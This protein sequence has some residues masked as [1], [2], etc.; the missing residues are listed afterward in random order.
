MHGWRRPQEH[1][2][3]RGRTPS[4]SALTHLRHTHAQVQTHAPQE[5]VH[6]VGPVPVIGTVVRVGRQPIHV[7]VAE[8]LVRRWLHLVQAVH[9]AVRLVPHVHCA[10]HL[11]A[12][13][14]KVP[15]A[16]GGG[17]TPFLGTGH[18]STGIRVIRW[19]T[20]RLQEA[21]CH[22][23]THVTTTIATHS[24]TNN[25]NA[26]PQGTW[27]EETTGRSS[28]TGKSRGTSAPLTCTKGHPIL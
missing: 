24:T 1:T 18:P 15:G 14:A 8:V 27:G 16:P 5:E 7:R 25:N 17:R 6:S 19:Y 2:K 23:P 10:A 4:R 28:R 22:A 20:W 12:D 21:A 26:S 13:A 9:V 3:G 11:T